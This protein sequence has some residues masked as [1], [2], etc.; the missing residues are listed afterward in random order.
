MWWESHERIGVILLY[1]KALYNPARSYHEE[2]PMVVWVQVAKEKIVRSLEITRQ[3]VR[4]VTA[5][6]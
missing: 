4:K 2:S 6:Q 1:D 5:M 3:A